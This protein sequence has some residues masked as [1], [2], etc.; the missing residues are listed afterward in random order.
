MA[1]KAQ[2][3][4]DN[5]IR[6]SFW[7]FLVLVGV[8]AYFC[9][10]PFMWSNDDKELGGATITLD[11][12]SDFL[13]V[14]DYQAFEQTNNKF[15]ETNFSLA[16]LN[17]LQQEIGP[18]AVIDAS[19]F[20]GEDL[21]KFRAVVLTQSA[22]SHDAW[23]PKLKAYLERGGTLILEMPQG[24]MRQIASA[25]GKG[26][27]RETQNFTY[28]AGMANQYV[29]AISSL[30]LSRITKLIGSAGPLE[31]SETFLT[32]DGVPVVYKKAFAQGTVITID[33]NYGML[34][35]SLQQGR[36]QDDFS[37]RNRFNSAGVETADLSCIAP[38][39]Y[40]LPLADILERFMLYTV[41]NSAFPVV[42]F[43][44]YFDATDGAVVVMHQEAGMGDNSTWLAQY[45][46][47]F[48]ASSTYF[49]DAPTQL[50]QEALQSFD[51]YNSEIALQWHMPSESS[52]S[53]RV[54]GPFP[55][56]PLKQALNLAEQWKE[57][58]KQLSDHKMLLSTQSADFRW[59]NRY[60]Q[61]FQILAASPARIDASYAPP[62]TMPG[63]GFGT[64][65]PF[66]PLD[67]Q[68]KLFNILEFP[69]V[70]PSL[71][72]DDAEQFLSL[73]QD[74][75]TS[76]HQLISVNVPVNP[77]KD[78]NTVEDFQAILDVY[79]KASEYSH[80]L[81][82]LRSFFRFTRARQN[83]ELRSQSSELVIKQKKRYVLRIETLAPESGMTLSIPQAIGERNFM[84]ARRGINRV[85][86]EGL[87]AD[88]IN[89]KAVTV[90]EVQ[91]LLLPLNK[92]FNA[93]DAVYE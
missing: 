92:G 7:G 9:V 68:G 67:T 10:K 18:V 45:E 51:S 13:L 28:A 15:E 75:Q 84:E 12:I 91:R 19:K 90:G 55:F 17:S 74:S 36:P 44:P 87:L 86:A 72:S 1:S 5:M 76:L 4:R 83:A 32:I 2:Q 88:T 57:L 77:Y 23:V 78:A 39:L 22:S 40:S 82:S 25:D 71:R 24:E 29:S 81:T 66:M 56:S 50:S 42:G 65:L 21:I 27:L 70:F 52:P 69:L 62:L 11:A 60:T 48:K 64:G 41:F 37:L 38:E 63:Y 20:A 6:F 26:G 30:D 34:L 33:F 73:L 54:T 89:T 79:A 46:A 58:E 14:V 43:W 35:T 80:W 47:S 16:W 61:A 85:Q 3:A 53:T 31:D 8:F 49:V 59:T 93:I